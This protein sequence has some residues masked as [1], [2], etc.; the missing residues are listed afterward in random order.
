M[1]IGKILTRSNWQIAEGDPLF[2][3]NVL[4]ADCRPNV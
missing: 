4:G 3:I 2:H 1:Y